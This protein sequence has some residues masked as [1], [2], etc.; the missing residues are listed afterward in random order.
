MLIRIKLNSSLKL[1]VA[2]GLI[3]ALLS[4]CGIR[5]DLKVPPPV[6]GS[7]NV[8]PDRIPSEDLDQEDRPDPDDLLNQDYADPDKD[9]FESDPFETDEG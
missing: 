5:G 6:F 9:D 2:S 1:T 7:S 4:G 8:D 3:A